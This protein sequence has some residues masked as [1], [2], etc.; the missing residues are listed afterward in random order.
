[1][2]SRRFGWGRRVEQDSFDCGIDIFN[3]NESEMR[4]RESKKTIPLRATSNHFHFRHQSVH[5][6]G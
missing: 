1:M 6:C 5:Y 4:E 3:L 2:K